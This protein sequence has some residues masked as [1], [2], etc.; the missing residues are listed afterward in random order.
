[1]GSVLLTCAGG[2]ELNEGENK[3]D[4]PITQH[5]TSSGDQPMSEDPPPTGGHEGA[6][7]AIRSESTFSANLLE[8]MA[9]LFTDY[10]DCMDDETMDKWKQ[11]RG[12]G[13]G[14]GGVT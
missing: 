14:V 9:V 5:T 12:S 10:Q 13:C 4:S 1:M 6:E 3:G 7:T 11:V 2:T 8:G